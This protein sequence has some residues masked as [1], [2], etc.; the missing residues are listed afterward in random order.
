MTIHLTI[1]IAV[2]LAGALGF[3]LLKG[4]WSELSRMV[5]VAGLIA[6]LLAAK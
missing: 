1:P 5:F 3:F 4:K 6:L 2:T